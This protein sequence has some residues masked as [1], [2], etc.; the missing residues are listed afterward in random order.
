MAYSSDS[1]R[2]YAM[3]VEGETS[4][5][6]VPDPVGIRPSDAVSRT[7]QMLESLLTKVTGLSQGQQ[8][9][10]RGTATA[11]NEIGQRL[12]SLEQSRPSSR[13]SGSRRTSRQS[14]RATS[15]NPDP[16]SLSLPSGVV[17]NP[18]AL[19]ASAPF[20]TALNLDLPPTYTLAGEALMSTTV[21][22]RR[23]A[24]LLS[25][26]RPDYRL[27]GRS[28]D[29]TLVKE[30]SRV[31]EPREPEDLVAPRSQQMLDFHSY[32]LAGDD[33]IQPGNLI[34]GSGPESSRD[35]R[36]GTS[37]TIGPHLDLAPQ[38]NSLNHVGISRSQAT[39]QT[40][41]SREEG[42][43]PY[44][45]DLRWDNSADF[46]FRQRE[47]ESRDNLSIRELDRQRTDDTELRSSST[48]IRRSDSRL[49]LNQAETIVDR[50][51]SV[52]FDSNYGLS[53]GCNVGSNLGADGGRRNSV[54]EWSTARCR[55]PVICEDV[56]MP[57]AFTYPYR[58]LPI[59]RSNMVC[60]SP[61]ICQPQQMSYTSLTTGPPLSLLMPPSSAALIYE[62]RPRMSVSYPSQPYHN[63]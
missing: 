47:A 48:E 55:M 63:L 50:Q 8:N 62:T 35:W 20:V 56:E 41:L 33:F 27:A 10:A 13:Q 11:L 16:Y 53:A 9:L 3:E 45:D 54:A 5:A 40:G 12:T 36:R 14:S 18:T 19:S 26:M 17:E 31:Q 39:P 49:L 25:K 23:S 61:W 34:S 32:P 7:E 43:R 1:F 24:R 60:S 51:N 46:R 38:V 44:N 4:A 21:P 2:D 29:W 6:V 58:S 22:L 42:R 57:G 59:A 30:P 15:P 52:N 37:L 28:D